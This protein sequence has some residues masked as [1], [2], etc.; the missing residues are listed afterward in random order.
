MEQLRAFVYDR[1]SRDVKGLASER[2]NADQNLENARFCERQ[3][4]TI[5]ER[6]T[7]PG[8]GASRH[9]KSRRTDYERMLEEIGLGRCDVLV[10]WEASRAYRDLKVYVT[11]RDLCVK[12]RVVLCYNGTVYDMTRRT[13]RFITGLNALQ[14]EDEADAIRDRVMRTVRLNAERG[15]PHGRIPYGYRRVYDERTGALLEQIPDDAQA[16]VVREIARRAAGGQS[17]YR[18]A[19]D[20]NDRGIPGPTGRPWSPEI[21]PDLLRKPTYIGKRQYQGTVIGDAVWEPILDEET[22]YACV[23]LFSDPGRLSAKGNAVKFLLSGIARCSVCRG[24]ARPRRSYAPD[25]WAYICVA[26]FKTSIQVPVLDEIVTLALLEY[27]ER[28]EF[29]AALANAHADDGTAA[30]LAQAQALEAQLAEARALAGRWENGRVVLS[31]ASLA[32]LEQQ[33]L[34]LIEDARSRAQSASVPLVLR[35]LAGPGARGKWIGGGEDLTWQRSVIRP[36]VV[37]W[38][39]PAG[40][41]VRGI[42][43]GRYDLEWKY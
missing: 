37:P 24:I 31:A 42:R 8:K 30:A 22:Y 40:K 3:G 36:L 10:V 23:R 26:C 38:M 28:P 35:Q 33:L 7:D 27:V 11:L 15:R 12:H 14:A 16:P 29:A 1:T 4:W 17:L 32:S 34:P 20:L 43:P 19:K 2:A 41:G 5:V 9:S 25:K 6:F 39:N 13:D 18:I 21:L